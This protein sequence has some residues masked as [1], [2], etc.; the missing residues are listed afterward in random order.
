MAPPSS[1]APGARPRLGR[2][3]RI[4]REL[5]AEA[6]HELGL[7]GLTL[8]AVAEHLGVSIAALYHH[9]SSKDDLMRL[10]AEYSVARVPLP[11]DRGQHWAVWLAEWADY[12][13]DAFLARPGL[14]AQYLE[15]GIAAETIA[16]NV[17]T[18]LGVLVRQGFDVLDANAAYELITS[19]AIGLAVAAI[20]ERAASGAGES[21]RDA[22]RRLLRER[23]PD[24]LP[25]LRALHR[26]I[27][28]HGRA[29]LRAQVTTVIRGITAQRGLR[30]APV[31]AALDEGLDAG[32]GD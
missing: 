10:A 4:S 31:R 5:I 23:G 11:E 17:D 30:W 29:P 24:E 22:H 1:A 3:P 28:D 8:R 12:N 26:A 18:I 6:A 15:G 7:D 2:P 19:C 27:A 32:P 9:V 25:H 20:R 13:H 16:G 14:L 21:I